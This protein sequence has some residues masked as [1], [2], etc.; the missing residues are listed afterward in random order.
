M[1]LRDLLQNYGFGTIR[2][3]TMRRV[4]PVFDERDS[5]RKARALNFSYD[6]F[7]RSLTSFRFL[8]NHKIVFFEIP[9]VDIHII[10]KVN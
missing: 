1:I 4:E 3:E 8:L 2:I 5:T 10:V 7:S 6:S 9:Q